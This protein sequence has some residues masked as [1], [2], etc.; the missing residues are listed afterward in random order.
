[1]T[2]KTQQTDFYAN[3]I[4]EDVRSRF[5][6]EETTKYTEHEI[7]RVYEFDDG[8]VVKYEWRSRE[9]SGKSS[10]FNHRFSIIK[11]PKP[12]PEKVKV[13]VIREIGFPD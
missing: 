3:S 4:I 9:K 1:M 11:A 8:C 6:N 7:E 13:G 10:G 5:V 2:R 12:N